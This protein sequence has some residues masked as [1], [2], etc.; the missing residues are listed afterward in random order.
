MK[1]IL[2]H[3]DGFIAAMLGKLDATGMAWARVGIVVLCVGA[4]MSADFGAAVSWK[5]ALFLA[6]LTFVAAFGPEAA[7]KAFEMKKYFIGCVA[8]LASA[9]LII[10]Q[11]GVD[12][13]Y[14]A[15]I[16]GLN[17]DETRVANVKWDGAQDASKDEKASLEMFRARHA[18]LMAERA[19]MGQELSWLPTVTP[20]GLRAEVVVHDK[21]IALETA[22]GGCKSKCAQRMQAKANLEK[23]IAAAESYKS[24]A[25][26]IA[27]LDK[28]ITATTKILDSKRE[29]ASH[30]EYKSSAVL[31]ANAQIAK[32]VA[33]LGFGAVKPSE[34][35]EEGTDIG[36]NMAMALAACGIPA[37][38]F[39]IAVALYK[40]EETYAE[41]NG[42]GPAQPLTPHERYHT[43]EVQ[44]QTFHDGKVVQAVA[45][46]MQ[47]SPLLLKLAERRNQMATA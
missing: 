25:D 31:H 39:L 20:D 28:Q 22:R 13:S 1:F 27:E 16:R 4:A 12:Q 21:E 15:G 19:K 40:R 11:F 37:F 38:T 29:V 43:K 41:A 2:K 3:M 47:N 5:H 26:E 7:Y 46:S 8:V 36:I 10:I 6:G 23:W 33:F 45:R 44:K 42:F 18:T 24:K 35:I 14:T 32:S 17:R 34:N 9:L 30:T